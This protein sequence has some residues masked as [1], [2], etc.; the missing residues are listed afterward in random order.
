MTSTQITEIVEFEELSFHNP[1][2]GSDM[3]KEA[4]AE[5]VSGLLKKILTLLSMIHPT[6]FRK[7]FLV[8][9]FCFVGLV[10]VCAG[11]FVQLV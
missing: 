1:T 7:L 11:I 3:L 10:W 9:C 4:Y 6:L 5:V 8:F 2:I